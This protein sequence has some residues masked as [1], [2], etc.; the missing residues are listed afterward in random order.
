MVTDN[1]VVREI[2]EEVQADYEF[3]PILTIISI[4]TSTIQLLQGCSGA[5]D[6]EEGQEMLSKNY[7]GAEGYSR[8]LLTS[9]KRAVKIAAFKKGTLLSNEEAKKIAVKICD[10]LRAAKKEELPNFD[11]I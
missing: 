9:T 11:L 3:I 7:Y 5:K 6:P 10:G 4:I 2:G 8:P 1:K